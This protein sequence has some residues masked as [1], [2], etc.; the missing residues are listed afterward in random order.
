MVIGLWATS[1]LST[2]G[3]ILGKPHPEVADEFRSEA[4]TIISEL[5]EMRKKLQTMPA[6]LCLVVQLK[7]SSE[8]PIRG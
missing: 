2:D 5:E 3:E 7:P 1:R 4:F 6:F 8:V